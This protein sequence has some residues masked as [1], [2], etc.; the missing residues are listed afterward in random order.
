MKYDI[1]INDPTPIEFKMIKIKELQGIFE[2]LRSSTTSLRPT[3]G[4]S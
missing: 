2:N 3:F 1:A 4:S